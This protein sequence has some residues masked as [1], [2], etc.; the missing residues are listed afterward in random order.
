MRPPKVEFEFTDLG[1]T[2]FGDSSI[3]ARTAKRL[4]LFKL[5][6]DVVPVKVRNR[7]ASDMETLWAII[8]SLA[9]GN[10]S[11]SDLHALRADKVAST[12][13]GLGRVPE[14]RRA[15]EWL[16]RLKPR[17]VKGLW[18]AAVNFAGRVAPNWRTLFDWTA[19]MVPAAGG[20]AGV[21]PCRQRLLKGR[22]GPPVRG[23]G[24]G[25][26]DQPDE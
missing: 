11:L 2:A 7:S 21:A 4:G 12:L 25:F 16:G 19:G 17:D 10:G 8:A 24:Q 14:A 5:F 13:L 3:L 6:G 15:G 22:F 20:A 23:A 9:R 26:L 1:L 18:R